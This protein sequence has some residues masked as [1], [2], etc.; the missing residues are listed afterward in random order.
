MFFLCTAPVKEVSG[1]YDHAPWLNDPFDTVIS[2]MMFFVPFVASLC[3]VRIL[4][5]RRSEPLPVARISDVLRGCRLVLTCMGVTLACEWIAV[6]IHDNGRAWND[7]TWI[8]IGLLAL[9]SLCMVVVVVAL[10]KSRDPRLAGGQSSST[11]PDWMGDTFQWLSAHSYL[12]GKAQ[13]SVSTAVEHVYETVASLARRHPMWS[14][15]GVCTLF[16]ITVGVNQGVREGYSPSATVVASLLL[17]AGM[18]GLLT[19]SGKYLGLVR[20]RNP[21]FG[22]RRRL[23]DALVITCLAVFVPFALRYHLWWIVGSTNAMAGVAQLTEL[24]AIFAGAIFVTTF[25]V[26]GALRLYP[27]TD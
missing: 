12:L 21:S 16:G 5:C 3:V 26:E 22:I 14:A 13:P 17:S 18:F 24:L 7:A 11:A 27:S 2:F 1:L 6:A 23:I 4:Q 15:L 20:S 19:A 10:R 8:Q 25:A 9:M